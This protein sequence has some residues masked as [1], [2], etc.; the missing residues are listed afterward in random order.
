MSTHHICLDEAVVALA[1]E[2]GDACLSFAIEG[3]A[4]TRFGIMPVTVKTKIAREEA[5]ALQ[6]VLQQFLA[7]SRP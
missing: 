7:S 4:D 2:T 5:E 3:D 6:L 1:Y